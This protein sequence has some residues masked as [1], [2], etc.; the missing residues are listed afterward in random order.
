MK[1]D[2]IAVIGAGGMARELLF[3]IERIN[4]VKPQFEFAGF[5]VSDLTQLGERDSHKKVVGDFKWL[6]QNRRSVDALA[7]GIG[8][9]AIRLKL[10]GEL[11]DLLPDI[12]WPAI[13]DPG[14][15]IDFESASIGRGALIAAG[16]V[17]TVNVTIEDFALCNLS[18]TIGHESRIG[19]GSVVNPGVNVSGGVRIGEGV[20]VGTGAQILQYLEVGSG[21]VVG[22]GTVITQ[23]VPPNTKVVEARPRINLPAQTVPAAKQQHA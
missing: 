15:V 2:R 7:L 1:L 20:L 14:A 19:K 3:A 12:S 17:A 18:C 21:S 23:D 16:V 11:T 5:V 10:A 8:S 4:R 9:P 13:I 6:Q 22:A